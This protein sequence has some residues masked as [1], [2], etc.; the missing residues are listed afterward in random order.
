MILF[1]EP[2]LIW[3][4][5]DLDEEKKEEEQERKLALEKNQRKR[6]NQDLDKLKTP[7]IKT[8]VLY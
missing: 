6:K 8:G 3:M 2:Q 7:I 4:K 1:W 5:K